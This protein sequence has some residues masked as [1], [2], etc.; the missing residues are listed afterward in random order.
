MPQS[1]SSRAFPSAS[2]RPGFAVQR[3][4]YGHMAGR[5]FLIQQPQET[6]CCFTQL[7]NEMDGAVTNDAQKLH[8]LQRLP[9]F[10]VC[11]IAHEVLYHQPIKNKHKC[12]RTIESGRNI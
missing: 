10:V 1:D 11:D 8:V 7:L 2:A 6:D 5:F 4:T 12:Q 3:I 9:R